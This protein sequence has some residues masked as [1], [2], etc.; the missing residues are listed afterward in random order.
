MNH[1]KIVKHLT[2]YLVKFGHLVTRFDQTTKF[3]QNNTKSIF[4]DLVKFDD[5]VKNLVICR[6]SRQGF[7]K[8]V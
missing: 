1:Q 6:N 2:K 4:G 5:L 3:G 7:D 8:S